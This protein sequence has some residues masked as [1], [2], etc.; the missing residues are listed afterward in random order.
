MPSQTQVESADGCPE[1]SDNGNLYWVA[2]AG[3][4]QIDRQKKH[5][6]IPKRR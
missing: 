5:L 3:L 2:P 6:Y 1:T 4:R